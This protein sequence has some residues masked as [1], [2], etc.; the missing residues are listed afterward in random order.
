MN[1]TTMIEKSYE[2]VR[3]HQGVWIDIFPITALPQNPKKLER[4][5]KLL[6]FSDLLVQDAFF[7]ITD[8][9]SAKLKLLSKIPLRLRRILCRI[10]RHLLFKPISESDV[11]D[12]YWGFPIRKARFAS[13]LF[14]EVIYVD[15][16]DGKFPVPKAYDKILSTVYGDYMTPPPPEKRN[17][18]HDVLILDLDR[19]YTEY[20]PKQ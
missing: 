9:L 8:N 18:G 16:E 12:Y 4:F 2:N 14:S 17:G 11:C 13:E 6:A 3:F 7:G 19:D 1:H 5:N 15:F 10:I 20:M